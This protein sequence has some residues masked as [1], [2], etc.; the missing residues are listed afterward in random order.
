MVHLLMPHFS[1]VDDGAEAVARPFFLR[2][3]ARK[4]ETLASGIDDLAGI[5]HDA[6]SAASRLPGLVQTLND[7]AA[8]LN[9]MAQEFSATAVATRD[10]LTV[11]LSSEVDRDEAM[12]RAQRDAS[13][14][15]ITAV[16][17]ELTGFLKKT[18]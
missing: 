7:A 4:R 3:L 6:R 14:L 5:A 2:Q 9:H 10:T 1:R 16:G 17:K 15:S 8:S 12:K 13:L 11:R 18:E